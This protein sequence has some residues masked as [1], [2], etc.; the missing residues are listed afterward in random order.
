MNKTLTKSARRMMVVAS[1]GM[2]TLTGAASAQTL[3]L[4]PFVTV[5]ST[6]MTGLSSNVATTSVLVVSTGTT[7]AT[8][9]GK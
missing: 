7:Q 4:D 9:T 3:T 2:I 6:G 5:Q 8:G 1:V